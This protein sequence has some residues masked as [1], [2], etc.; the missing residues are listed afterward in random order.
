[1]KYSKIVALSAVSSAIGLVL[2]LIGAYVDVLDLS[3]LFMASLALMLPLSKGYRL[4]AFLSYLACVILGFLLSGFR[5]QIMLPFTLFFGLHPIINDLQLKYKFNKYLAIILKTIWFIGTLFAM[6]Y[7]TQIFVV[8]NE[9]VKQYIVPIIAIGGA[10]LFWV[11]DIFMF[12]FQ[13]MINKI[14][15]QLKL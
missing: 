14:V 3:C 9:I 8:E 13:E 15:Q 4:G 1:M 5:I 12:K 7:L 11:Y 6:Y 2:L 10:V